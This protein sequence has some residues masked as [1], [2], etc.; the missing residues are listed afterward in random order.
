MIWSRSEKLKWEYF[1]ASPK[2]DRLSYFCG[3]IKAQFN[4]QNALNGKGNVYVAPIFMFD[5][6]YVQSLEKNKY[7]LEYNQLKF[8]LLEIYAR[9]LRKA[10]LSSGI[11]TYEKWLKFWEKIYDKIINELKTDLYNVELESNFGENHSGIIS[12]KLKVE[13]DLKELT[14]YSSDK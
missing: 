8:D 11:N 4:D 12:W 1:K 13:N 6:S 5:C 10:Y 2:F 9:K 14:E 3:Y 7:L